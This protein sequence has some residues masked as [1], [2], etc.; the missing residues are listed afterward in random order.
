MEFVKNAEKNKK[1]YCHDCN[2]KIEIDEKKNIKN[3]KMLSYQN[4]E[5]KIIICKCND[6]LNKS[7][8][9]KNYQVCEVYSR[10]VGYLRPVKQWNEGKQQEFKERWEYKN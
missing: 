5:E 3:G 1:Y 6:C 4:G 7:A 2:K 10:I 9:L 8:A